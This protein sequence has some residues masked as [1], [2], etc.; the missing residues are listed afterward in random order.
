MSSRSPHA[1]H[2]HTPSAPLF[3]LTPAVPRTARHPQRSLQPPLF[4]RKSPVPQ[5]PYPRGKYRSQRG[6][7]APKPVRCLSPDIT[8][9]PSYYSPEASRSPG[10]VTPGAITPTLSQQ[11][12]LEIGELE[13]RCSRASSG[14]RNER[15][16]IAHTRKKAVRAF[17]KCSVELL[18]AIKREQ[19]E[20]EWGEY[21][22]AIAAKRSS[23]AYPFNGKRP[24]LVD[25]RQSLQSMLSAKLNRQS[26]QA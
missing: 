19:V 6:F 16:A 14:I 12:S 3:T 2:A 22:R 7:N 21:R 8:K 4:S 18:R 9:M 23:L 1:L 11:R 26:P 17:G 15:K 24:T 5:S 20:K 13:V 25:F 10:S